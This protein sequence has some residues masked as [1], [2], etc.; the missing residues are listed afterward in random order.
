MYHDSFIGNK[1]G[2]YP[3]DSTILVSPLSTNKR[4]AVLNGQYCIIFSQTTK[5][6]DTPAILYK[7][8]MY[9]DLIVLGHRH[10]ELGQ[11]KE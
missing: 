9:D 6:S 5:S 3:R 7:Y 8:N 11:N 10:K 4:A 1:E 2:V